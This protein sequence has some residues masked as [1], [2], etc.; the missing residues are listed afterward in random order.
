MKKAVMRSVIVLICAVLVF[1]LGCSRK[2]S[3]EKEG[4]TRVEQTGEHQISVE[5]TDLRQRSY[6][7]VVALGDTHGDLAVTRQ[8]LRLVEAIDE[9]DYGQEDAHGS[10]REQGCC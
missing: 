2:V 7:R 4:A 1:S 8:V 6:G 5:A 9:E 3:D 10:T